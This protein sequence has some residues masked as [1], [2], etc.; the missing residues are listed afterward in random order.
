MEELERDKHQ[1]LTIL[2][3]AYTNGNNGANLETILKD[4]QKQLP[5]ILKSKNR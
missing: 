4:M 2:K 5:T 3:N 1:L